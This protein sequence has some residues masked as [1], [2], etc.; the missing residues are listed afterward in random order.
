MLPGG[1][2]DEKLASPS[3]RPTA[4]GD[5]TGTAATARI[6]DNISR[7]MGGFFRTGM[8][9]LSGCIGGIVLVVLIHRYTNTH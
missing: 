1:I 6:I 8:A 5:W 9:V 2:L 3:G 7:K 4:A